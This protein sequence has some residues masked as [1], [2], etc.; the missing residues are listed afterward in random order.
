MAGR[1]GGG[2]GSARAGGRAAV[3]R[4]VPQMARSHSRSAAMRRGT[5]LRRETKAERQ[6]SCYASRSVFHALLTP[7]F[8]SPRRR[9]RTTTRIQTMSIVRLCQLNCPVVSVG[10]IVELGSLNSARQ[11]HDV[12]G[13][14]DVGGGGGG[15]H[16]GGWWR[17]VNGGRTSR[18]WVGLVSRWG[19]TATRLG[20]GRG[21]AASLLYHSPQLGGGNAAPSC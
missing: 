1:G 7:A 11:A 12:A 10:W 8:L 19:S 14:W 18:G 16:D 21:A 17:L 5:R 6:A 20:M 15:L 4:Q 3:E 9:P 13:R 2:G